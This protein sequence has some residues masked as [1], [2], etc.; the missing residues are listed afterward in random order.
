MVTN[1]TTA[2][3]IDTIRYSSTIDP[4]RTTYFDLGAGNSIT[5][6]AHSLCDLNAPYGPGQWDKVCPAT[7]K[8]VTVNVNNLEVGALAAISG[9]GSSRDSIINALQP[10]DITTGPGSSIRGTLIAPRSNITFGA[11]SKLE[12]SF[13]GKSITLSAGTTASYHKDCDPLIDGNCDGSPDC[14]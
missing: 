6:P 10:G 2:R 11:S 1:Q 3:A 13:F 12:G 4:S 9:N 8:P 14:Q 5:F 7:N